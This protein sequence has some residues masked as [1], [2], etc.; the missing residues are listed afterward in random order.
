M[1]QYDLAIIG[2]GIHGA[3]VAQ[4]ASSRGYRVVVL[5]QYDGP[6]GGTSSKS[7]KLIHGGLRYLESGQ[8]RLVRECL[9]ERERLLDEQPDL[10][11]L[12]PFNIPVY[13][14]MRRRPWMIAAGLSLYAMLGGKGFRR[15]VRRDWPQLDGLRTH[16]SL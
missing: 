8:F 15:I 7:S 6:A 1:L 2:A 13:P 5:E 14:H 3:A 12:I 10:V 4:V 16:W 9:V 11:R